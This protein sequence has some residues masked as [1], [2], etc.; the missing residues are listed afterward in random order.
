MKL[1]A[2][3]R[4]SGAVQRRLGNVQKS[5]MHVQSCCFATINL[6]LFCHSHCYSRHCFLSSL[7]AFEWLG[8]RNIVPACLIIIY[9]KIKN[10]QTILQFPFN[11]HLLQPKPCAVLHKSHWYSFLTIKKK[12]RPIQKFRVKFQLPDSKYRKKG[13][14]PPIKNNNTYKKGHYFDNTSFSAEKSKTEG[15][16]DLPANLMFYSYHI[17]SEFACSVW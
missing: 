9:Y 2:L 8:P 11:T 5:M 3:S 7:M 15:E 6:L 17:R 4:C 12:E 14:W 16:V 13:H 1:Q 10:K